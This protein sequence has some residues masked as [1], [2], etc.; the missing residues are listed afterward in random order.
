MLGAVLFV[1]LCRCLALHL[2]L[3]VMSKDA[4]DDTTI[5]SKTFDLYTVQQE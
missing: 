1:V 3:S 4:A 2:S 5:N